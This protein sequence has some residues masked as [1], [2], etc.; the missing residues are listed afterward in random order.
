MM[1]FTIVDRL[2]LNSEEFGYLLL[3]SLTALAEFVLWEEDFDILAMREQVLA[4]RLELGNKVYEV[5][6]K[7]C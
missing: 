5:Y 1:L 2:L 7:V 4:M 3:G 6:L